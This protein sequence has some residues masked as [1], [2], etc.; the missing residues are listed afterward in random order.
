LRFL[1]GIEGSNTHE[2]TLD[3][4]KSLYELLPI[5]NADT[6]REVLR[7]PEQPTTGVGARANVGRVK[8]LSRSLLG[9]ILNDCAR[10]PQDEVAVLE[11]GILVIRVEFSKPRISLFSFGQVDDH[12]LNRYA[13]VLGHQG[14]RACVRRHRM[15]V[16]AHGSS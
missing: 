16:K 15:V 9:Q 13:E 6:G 14:G 11:N 5:E 2:P 12:K 10:F 8:G 1:P 4:S 3:V 7:T